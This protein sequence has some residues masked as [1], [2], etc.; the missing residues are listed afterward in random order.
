MKIFVVLF[1]NFQTLV[2]LICILATYC[3]SGFPKD[4]G[5]YNE[6][7]IYRK[8]TSQY[9]CIIC[10]IRSYCTIIIANCVIYNYV[11][12]IFPLINE[13]Q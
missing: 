9:T 6:R 10:V 2:S 12:Y 11:V 13:L 3:R 1:S 8:K 4:F 7:F 5:F